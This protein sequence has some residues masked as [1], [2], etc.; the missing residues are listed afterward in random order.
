VAGSLKELKKKYPLKGPGT[1]QR[2]SSESRAIK[3]RQAAASFK[4]D[5]LNGFY[6]AAL[7]NVAQVRRDHYA[8]LP[9]PD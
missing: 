2:G 8:T 9:H 1:Q 4:S 7:L 6:G 5:D 3:S